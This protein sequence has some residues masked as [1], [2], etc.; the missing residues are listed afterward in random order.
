MSKLADYTDITILLD[1]SGSMRSTAQAT[2]ESLVN[3]IKDQQ[4]TPGS[5]NLTLAEFHVPRYL[6]YHAKNAPVSTFNADAIRYTPDGGST[7]LRDAWLRVMEERGRYFASLPEVSRPNKVVFVVITDGFDNAS[8]A[9]M[10][11]VRR[12]VEIQETAF[13]WKFIY[14]GAN[15]DAVAE[16]ANYG[17]P[18][19]QSL[20]YDVNA[21]KCASSSLSGTVSSYRSEG[22]LRSF[23]DE[24]RKQ[25]VTKAG[26]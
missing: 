21:V 24:E 22:V 9:T 13:N 10:T 17:V 25:A 3:F 14:L 8:G 4:A 15:Q 7:A 6:H 16:G 23:T 19:G 12:R 20:T 2:L 18:L 1:G 26:K 11:E 5:A